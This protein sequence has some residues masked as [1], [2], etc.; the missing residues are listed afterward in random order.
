MK[1]GS[2]DSERIFLEDRPQSGP[3]AAGRPC[4]ALGIR[5]RPTVAAVAVLLVLSV[6]H[7]AVEAKAYAQEPVNAAAQGPVDKGGD[8]PMLDK[9]VTLT[10]LYNNVPQDTRL[11]TAWGMA[12]LVEG[13]SKT[14]LFD[15]GGDGDVLLEN[16]DVL[17]KNPSDVELI[18]LSHIH[19]DHVGGLPAFLARNSNVKVFLPQ[20]FPASFKKEI[21]DTGATV[22]N[23]RDP[24]EIVDGIYTTGEMGLLLKEQALILDTP[25]GL[26]LVTGCSHPGVSNF[27]T[28]AVEVCPDRTFYLVTGGFHLGGQSR[29]E[30]EKIVKALRKLNIQKVGPSHCT[31]DPAMQMFREAWGDDFVDLGCGGQITIGGK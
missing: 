7:A 4:R 3:G 14:I 11:T 20:S 15:T 30:I 25:K 2:S 23:V 12:C 5:R 10:I 13:A 31:G 26:V 16:M 8:T 28:R 24:Q 1:H 27:A 9:P 17:G 19:G 22:S 29:R 21:E 6:T 18:V